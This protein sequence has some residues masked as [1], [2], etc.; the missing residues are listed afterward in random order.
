MTVPLP[1][2]LDPPAHGPLLSALVTQLRARIWIGS[3]ELASLG[4]LDSSGAFAAGAGCLF[5]CDIGGTK[6][7]SA[8]ADM[9]GAILGEARA[10]TPT[11]GGGAVLDLV[12]AHFE[13]LTADRGAVVR[14]AGIGLPGAVH[15]TTGKLE[16]APNLAGLAGR[17]MRAVFSD[18]LGLPVAVENDVN[19][20]A[21]GEAWL[22][23]GA[24]LR[25]TSGGL[26]F[27]ALGTGIGMGLAWGD[28][29]LRGAHGAAGEIAA[30]PIGA[31]P[32]DPRT[33]HCGA[34]ESLV[35]GT[36]LL[37]DY[38]SLGGSNPGQSLREISRNAG[39]D[40][41]YGQVMR[42]LSERTAQAVLAVDAILNPAI[43]VFGG[44]IGSQPSLLAGILDNLASI[45]PMDMP[46]PDCRH[47]ILGNR[48][49]VLGGIRAARLRYADSLI[50]DHQASEIAQAL[51]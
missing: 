35:S 51:R 22:G 20:A 24:S 2:L 43:V 18:R 45:M 50:G 6:V 47:S 31:D 37:A 8:V 42:R 36:A 41:A 39:Q 15:P 23:H 19:M 40:M 7:H 25:D 10:D 38:R 32:R 11:E 48:A 1:N 5:A 28:R 21:L 14:A 4:W 12:A 49:G 26:A 30:L 17:D 46:V 9:N 29:L 33:H 13:H 27:I 3:G 44:G 16:R 34:L